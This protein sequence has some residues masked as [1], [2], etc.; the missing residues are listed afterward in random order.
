MLNKAQHDLLD[1]HKSEFYSF[2]SELSGN[3]YKQKLI[4]QY[5]LA[6]LEFFPMEK[7]PY[8]GES[9][10]WVCDCGCGERD[11]ILVPYVTYSRIGVEGLIEAEVEGIWVSPC[12]LPGSDP[13]EGI[14]HFGMDAWDNEMDD[15]VDPKVRLEGN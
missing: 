14:R 5:P 4:S 8:L 3:D 15:L 9:Q 6:N 13:E 12:I 2:V 7:L 1:K 10:V 11:P